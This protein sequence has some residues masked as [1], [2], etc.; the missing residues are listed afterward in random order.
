MFRKLDPDSELGKQVSA[1]ISKNKE[2][3]HMTK[4]FTEE[5]YQE[6]V[7]TQEELFFNNVLN[8]GR[9]GEYLYDSLK[10]ELKRFISNNDLEE[11]A[12]A[13]FNPLTRDWAHERFVKKEK[14]YYWRYK[15][16]DD[17]GYDESFT[18][19]EIIEAGYNPDMFDKKEVE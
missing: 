6:I 3:E 14:K 18:E 11:V 16:K 17:D 8:V 15:K 7:E 1:F 10:T 4:K 12:L 19:K 13:I 5:Q 2:E 9:D